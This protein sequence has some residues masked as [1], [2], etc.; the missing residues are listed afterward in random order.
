MSMAELKQKYPDSIPAQL[1]FFWEEQEF[2]TEYGVADGDLFHPEKGD[3]STGITE[4]KG[5]E[6]RRWAVMGTKGIIGQ[7]VALGELDK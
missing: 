4:T 6:G 3:M 2:Y 7:V 1:T 5:Y